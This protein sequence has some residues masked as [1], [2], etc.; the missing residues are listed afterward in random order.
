MVTRQTYSFLDWLGDMGGLFDALYL[1]GMIILAPIS[2]FALKTELLSSMFRYR[3]SEEGLISRTSSR[4]KL[5]F[6][7]SYFHASSLEGCN[8]L[9]SLQSDF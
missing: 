3:G 2:K 7:K 4:R 6:F 8:I 9:G 1:L 5:D